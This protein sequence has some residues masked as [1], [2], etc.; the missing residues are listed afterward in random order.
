MKQSSKLA[1][2]LA[3]F[4]SV[5]TFSSCQKD[6]SNITDI[7]KEGTWRVTLYND[8]GTDELYHFTDYTFTFSNGTVTATKSGS[9][10]TGTYSSGT[11]DSQHKFILDF[12]STVPFEE[13][14]DDWHILE[15]TSTKI[16][17]EDVS[18]GSGE[19][20]LLTFEKI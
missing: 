10:V 17:L 5:L 8:S 15:E 12:G 11:D 14:N 19:T 7:V 16:R 20:D 18:G 4:A 9:S 2:S 3:I 13:L 6:D 1:F